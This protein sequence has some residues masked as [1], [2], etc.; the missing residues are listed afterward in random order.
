M[1]RTKAIWFDEI[2]ENIN[3]DLIKKGRS[4]MP[5]PKSFNPILDEGS[6]PDL[7]P[8]PSYDPDAG[9]AVFVTPDDEGQVVMAS[10]NPLADE[11]PTTVFE[12]PDDEGQ[13]VMS[14]PSIHDN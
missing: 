11:M 13:V 1:K 2:T 10:P 3:Y 5:D 4:A 7:P 12:T 6:D 14:S 9:T 8:A